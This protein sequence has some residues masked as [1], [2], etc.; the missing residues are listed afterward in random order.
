MIDRETVDTF[1]LP[2]ECHHDR[3]VIYEDP[4]P[5]DDQL[6]YY[7]TPFDVVGEVPTGYYEEPEEYH[8]TPAYCAA[9]A[10]RAAVDVA[11]VRLDQPP[12]VDPEGADPI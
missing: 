6:P 4:N 10:N 9:V 3:V 1:D 8:V 12:A 5:A 2:D 7:A 11:E